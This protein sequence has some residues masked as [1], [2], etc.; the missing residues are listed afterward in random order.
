M[1]LFL[2]PWL[3]GAIAGYLGAFVTRMT[4]L[5]YAPVGPSFAASHLELISVTLFSV[6]LFNEP[7]NAYKILAGVLI[8]LA[9]CAW[10]KTK[11]TT[12]RAS[13]SRPRPGRRVGRSL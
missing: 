7:L 11:R 12:R 13:G 8:L 3:Y 9:S 2:N 6:W 1:R 10:R 5:R 4:L